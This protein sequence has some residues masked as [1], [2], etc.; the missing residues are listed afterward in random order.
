MQVLL[1][2]PA[3]GIL[4]GIET[5]LARMSRW[6][7]NHGH[8]VCL[9]VERG[10]NWVETLPK[11]ARC[12]V[13]GDRFRELYFYFHAR[14]LWHSLRLAKPD[15]I[16]S[17]H[18]GSSFIA[19]QL[20]GI[21]GND[22]KVIAGLYGSFF[23]NWYHR[24]ATMRPWS[25]RR[26]YLANYLRCIPPNAR[27]VC[28]VDQIEDLE[29]VHGQKS[30]LWPTPIDTAVF[31]SA[32]RKPRR[33]KIVS[34][35]RMDVMKQYNLYMVDVV[36]ELLRRGHEVSWT[37]YGTGDYEPALRKRVA[38]EGLQGV[39]SLEGTVPYTRFWQALSDAYVF[40]GMG[41]AVLEAA[42]FRVPNVVALAYD[43]QGLTY[44]PTYV[45]PP[46]SMTPALTHP[47]TLKVVDEIDRIMRL[48]PEAYRA[49]EDL[50]RQ[51]V[52]PHQID[53]S[54]ERFLQ[55]VGEAGVARQSRFLQLT[56]YALWL[57]RRA[58]NRRSGEE[59]VRHPEAPIYGTTTLPLEA[60]ARVAI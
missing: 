3:P 16:K 17:F 44:G 21:I 20:A 15:V 22:C 48:N 54:M 30:V 46:G 55:L 2:Y 43:R 31:E 59:G 39:I 4:G 10:D 36:K 13:L 49:E 32:T 6:L 26:L 14:Q 9:L 34:V 27:L 24:P 29:Q 35:G 28:G 47:P 8:Q 52:Q 18:L 12:I 33:G 45:A 37:V 53:A 57:V 50:V 38:E 58:I 5:L 1:I 60:T 42:L 51:Q 7:V 25:D 41:T 11:E 40:V 23:F 19:T 56:N